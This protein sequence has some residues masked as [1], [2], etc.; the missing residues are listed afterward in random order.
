MRFFFPVL[1][2]L[3]LVAG[4]A[5]ESSPEPEPIHLDAVT[6]AP[7]Q[8]EVGTEAFCRSGRAPTKM[9]CC[10]SSDGCSRKYTCWACDVGGL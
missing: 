5:A 10:D 2:A 1:A 8:G 3:A 7:I 6:H 4:C 9:T